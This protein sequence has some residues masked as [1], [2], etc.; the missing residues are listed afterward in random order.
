MMV[1][2]EETSLLKQ[3]FKVVGH[4]MREYVE[5]IYNLF[6]DE[7]PGELHSDLHDL[8]IREYFANI[9]FVLL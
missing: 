5:H 7:F 2:S 1:G 9:T 6:V 8:Y 4:A 3:Y